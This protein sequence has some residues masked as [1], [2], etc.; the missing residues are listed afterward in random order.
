[1]EDALYEIESMHCFS[2]RR[3][4]S[5]QIDTNRCL[6]RHIQDKVQVSNGL[7]LLTKHQKCPSR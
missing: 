7:D 1:M 4:L 6:C 2:G 5:I 3:Y